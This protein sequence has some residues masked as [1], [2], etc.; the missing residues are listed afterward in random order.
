M[1]ATTIHARRESH[2]NAHG[3][4][5]AQRSR[6][7]LDTRK[8][9]IGVPYV[10]AVKLRETLLHVIQAEKPLMAEHRII[11]LHGMALRENEAIA[12]GVV[13][14]FRINRK[15]IGIQH[16]ESVYHAHIAT[17]MPTTPSHDDVKRILSEIPPKAFKLIVGHVLFPSR[18]VEAK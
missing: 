5:M 9:I 17:D 11:G 14:V 7:H 8:L 2:P 3:K 13:K 12:V 6:V 1:I 10:G 16:H 15:V 18:R 4:A